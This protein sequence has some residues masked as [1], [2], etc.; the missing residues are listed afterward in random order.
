MAN[1]LEMGPPDDGAATN[2]EAAVPVAS[3]IFR[4]HLMLLAGL[5]V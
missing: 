2:M 3:V 4:R 5:R 1:G